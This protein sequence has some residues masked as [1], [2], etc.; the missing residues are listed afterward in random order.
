M[1]SFIINTITDFWP[2]AVADII[3]ALQPQNIPN[4][5]VRENNVPF[6]FLMKFFGDVD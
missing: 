1:S 3:G 4:A 2:T 6:F 5:N